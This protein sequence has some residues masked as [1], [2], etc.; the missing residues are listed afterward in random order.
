MTVG[1]TGQK[2][3][4]CLVQFVVY[5]HLKDSHGS[6]FLDKSLSAR[7]PVSPGSLP[8]RQIENKTIENKNQKQTKTSVIKTE[9]ILKGVVTIRIRTERGEKAA[10]LFFCLL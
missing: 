8:V 1:P 2:T 3:P 5:S 4:A 10:G 6:T 7:L 9:R